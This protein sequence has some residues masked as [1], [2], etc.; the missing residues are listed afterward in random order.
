MS[1]CSQSEWERRR[2]D[3]AIFCAES[4]V[5]PGFFPEL[6]RM[7]STDYPCLVAIIDYDA[8]AV[9]AHFGRFLS[10]LQ[11]E[12]RE[13][14]HQVNPYRI[15]VEAQGLHDETVSFDRWLPYS[16]LVRTEFYNDLM[17]R[18]GVDHVMACSIATGESARTSLTLYR[19]RSEGGAFD[20]VDQRRINDLR[21]FVRAAVLMRRLWKANSRLDSSNEDLEDRALTGMAGLPSGQP[22][23][24]Q[25]VSGILS[26]RFGLTRRE[27]DVA[28]S[29]LEGVSYK[30]AAAQL[31]IS[32]HTIVS[33]ANSIRSKSG[34]R[35]IRH[36][37]KMVAESLAR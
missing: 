26:K 31:G 16:E 34:A 32:F 12:Y 24:R 4:A 7:V 15:I 25:Q 9:D 29:L 23:S 5:K 18:A 37:V 27:A 10:S 19:S 28:L 13:Y 17:A 21:P 20:D 11:R 30:E 2:L 14:Y 22:R 1:R 3:Y 35:S 6:V 8:H 33:H 36:A